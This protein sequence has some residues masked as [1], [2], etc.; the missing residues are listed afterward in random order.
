ME[1]SHT[2]YC[3][4]KAI[5]NL[6][7]TTSLQFW[8]KNMPKNSIEE[9]VCLWIISSSKI[10]H[11]AKEPFCINKCMFTFFLVEFYLVN[12]ISFK[13]EQC[14]CLVLIFD[15]VLPVGYTYTYKMIKSSIST[16]YQSENHKDYL[17]WQ[18]LIMF[19]FLLNF[20][21]HNFFFHI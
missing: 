13:K 14:F 17:K 2:S 20:I 8:N 10:K 12:E 6:T 4:I 15:Y 11:I 16:E 3:W 19:Q 1:L 9:V 7:K 18:N 21:F 5:F